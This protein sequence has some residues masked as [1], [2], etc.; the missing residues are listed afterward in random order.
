MG[1]RHDA[2]HCISADG[3]LECFHQGSELL[4][5]P[6]S[7]Q[8]VSVHDPDEYLNAAASPSD[9]AMR[10]THI[11][12]AYRALADLKTAGR[13]SAIGVGSKDWQVIR[14]IAGAVKLDWV[15]LANSFTIYRHPRTVVDFVDQLAA[16]GICIIN[17]AVFH[18]GFLTGGRFFDYRVVAPET[19]GSL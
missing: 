16:Q 7:T 10:L 5:A 11:L 18:A 14:K 13:V 4:G 8:L 2:E 17:S 12:D 9:R 19:D 6:Y 3:I 15:M 1:L